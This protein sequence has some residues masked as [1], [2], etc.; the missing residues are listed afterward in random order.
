MR[1]H[2]KEEVETSPSPS[3]SKSYDVS[4][5]LCEFVYIYVIFM[6]YFLYLLSRVYQLCIDLSVLYVCIYLIW[7]VFISSS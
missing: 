1:Y 2:S 5:I 6:Y 3:E 4:V 7:R